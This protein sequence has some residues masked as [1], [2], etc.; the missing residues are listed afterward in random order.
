MTISNHIRQQV[1]TAFNGTNGIELAQRF[2][3]T[4]NAVYQIILDAKRHRATPVPPVPD[5]SPSLHEGCSCMDL[6][7]Q[8]VQL[9]QECL[10]LKFREACIQMGVEADAIREKLPAGYA[11]ALFQAFAFY[12]DGI[13]SAIRTVERLREIFALP[14]PLLPS[15]QEVTRLRVA[16]YGSSPHTSSGTGA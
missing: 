16:L 12:D 3:L 2:K 6:S 8:A 11:M 15:S 13:F 7:D 1:V 10:Q 5:S 4:L 9:Q 14:D